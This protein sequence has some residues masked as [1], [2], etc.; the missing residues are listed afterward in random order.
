MSHE[1]QCPERRVAR[2][3]TR[4]ARNRVPRSGAT[5]R[6]RICVDPDVNRGRT[7]GPLKPNPPTPSPTTQATATPQ[8]GAITG[9]LGAPA[10][11]IPPLTVYA[12][13]TVDQRIWFSVDV[14]RFPPPLVTPRPTGTFAPGTE[15]RY[16]ITSVAPGTYYVLAYRND[17][18]QPDGP[19]LY[20]R[21][22]AC[23]T[24]G[25]PSTCVPPEDQSLAVVTVN[26]G[27]T[28]TGIDILDWVG[29][30]GPG[31]SS[32]SFPPRPTPR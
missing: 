15:P 11:G 1:Q 19:A 13:S 20:S 5:S 21:R 23:R 32:P 30:A 7:D 31:R 25:P 29:P 12:I 3:G 17:G 24:G 27:Q 6:A 10:E 2:C 4:R 28:T 14:A 22:I 16:T 8:A 18:E 9:Q 26:A